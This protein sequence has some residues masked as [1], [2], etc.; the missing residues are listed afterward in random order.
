MSTDRASYGI[1]GDDILRAAKDAATGRI[2]RSGKEKKAFIAVGAARRTILTAYR[3]LTEGQAEQG[4]SYPEAIAENH[5]TVNKAQESLAHIAR[6][7]RRERF[8]F[9]SK[10]HGRGKIRALVLCEELLRITDHKLDYAVFKSFMDAYQET[11]P[12]DEGEIL[13]IPLFIRMLCVIKAAEVYSQARDML[14]SMQKA[15]RLYEKLTMTQSDTAKEKILQ[16]AIGHLSESG[17]ATLYSLFADNDDF[18]C[19]EILSGLLRKQNMSLRTVSINDRQQKLRISEQAVNTAGT[20]RFCEMLSSER[21]L[22]DFSVLEKVLRSDGVYCSLDEP[23]QRAYCSACAKIAQR[24]RISQGYVAQKACDLGDVSYYLMDR[25]GKRE[26]LSALGARVH[27][28]SNGHKLA[29]HISIQIV[30]TAVLVLLCSPAGAVP[31]ALSVF[32]SFVFVNTL[33]MRV[34][35]F[36]SKPVPVPRMHIEG[37]SPEKTVTAVSVLVTDEKALC[38]C[39]ERIETHYLASNLKNTYYAVLGDFPDSRN[40][41]ETDDEKRLARLAA[42]KTRMLN[43]K[44]SDG[45]DIFC[46]LIRHRTHNKHDDIYMGYERKRGAVM[47]FFDLIRNDAGRGNYSVIAGELPHGIKYALLLDSDTCLPKG[48]L[49]S[50]IG[51]AMHP[52]NRAVTEKGRVTKGYGIFIP[53]MERIP[54]SDTGFMHA[55][56]GTGGVSPYSSLVCDYYHDSFGEAVFGGKGLV[57]IDAFLE[58]LHGRIEDNTVLSHDMLES[59]FVKGAYVSDVILYDSEPK[60]LISWWKRAHRWIRGDWQLLP[61]LLAKKDSQ[62]Y[63][64]PL[65]KWKILDNMRRSLTPVFVLQSLLILPYFGM[66]LYVWLSLFCAFEEA[67]IDSLAALRMYMLDGHASVRELGI[68]WERCFIDFMSLPYATARTVDAVWRALHRVLFSHRNML[69]WQTA[70][71]SEKKTREKPLLY[72]AELWACFWTG[73]RL[74]ILPLFGFHGSVILGV[75]FVYA[76]FALRIYDA[77]FRKESITDGTRA[78]YTELA[79]DIWDFFRNEAKAEHGYIPPDNVQIYPERPPVYNASPTNI[80]MG[81]TA[82]VCAHDLGLSDDDELIHRASVCMDYMDK[83]EKWNGHLYNWYDL[84]SA[85]KLT[86]AYVSTVDS[87]NLC[88]CLLCCA[89]ALEETGRDEALICA[90]RMR[91]MA[92]AMDFAALYDNE[93]NLFYIG[94]DV[95]R[96]ELTQSRYDLLASEAR[97]TYLTACAL[98][99]IPQKSWKALGR[100]LTRTQKGRSLAS[101]SGT[102]FEYLMPCLFTGIT[103]DTLMDECIHAAV[104]EFISCADGHPWGISESGYYAFDR[105]MYYQYRAFGAPLLGLAPMYSYE[106]VYAPYASCLA[107]MC[108]PE[109]ACENLKSFSNIGARGRYGFYEAVDFTPGRVQEGHECEIVKSYMAHH[110]GMS[111]CALA[112]I[113]TDNMLSKRFMHIPEMRAVRLYCDEKI[114]DDALTLKCSERL[115]MNEDDA[116]K[117]Y[118]PPVYTSPARYPR[119]TFLTNGHMTA[120]C[121]DSGISYLRTGDTFVTRYRR[122][123]IRGCFGL[124]LYIR[125]GDKVFCI[126][127]SGGDAAYKSF[128]FE[129]YRAAVETDT[130]DIRVRTESIVAQGADALCIKITVAN[131]GTL[132]KTLEIGAFAGI[133]LASLADDTAHPA[134]INLTTDAERMKD[135]VMFIRRGTDRR[136]AMYAYAAFSESEKLYVSADGLSAIGRH[137]SYEDAM[138]MRMY[139]D[140]R[141]KS[142]TEPVLCMKSEIRADGGESREYTFVFAA[143]EDRE[144]TEAAVS[145]QMSAD[146]AQSRSLC[147]AMEMS[148]LKFMGISEGKAHILSQVAVRIASGA[149]NVKHTERLSRARMDALYKYSISGELPIVAV[150]IG[151]PTQ[152][153]MLK[154]LLALLRFCAYKGEY[155]DLVIIGRYDM[156]YRCDVKSYITDAAATFMMSEQYG[157]NKHLHIADGY[158]MTDDEITLIRTVAVLWIDASRSLD[159]QFAD[160]PC[161]MS[162][163]PRICSCDSV[164]NDVSGEFLPSGAYTFELGA[165]DDTPLPWS[166]IICSPKNEQFGTLV[167][168]SGGGYTWSGNCHDNRLTP[169][170]CDI[171]HDTQGE[172]LLISDKENNVRTVTHSRMQG[173]GNVRITHGFGYTVFDNPDCICHA[174]MTVF[175]DTCCSQKISLLELEN[176][177]GR[178]IKLTLRYMADR[179]G[180]AYTDFS[181]GIACM[182]DPHMPGVTYM[183]M[184]NADSVRF[185]GDREGELLFYSKTEQ[186]N[187]DA[188]MCLHGDVRLRPNEKRT[189]ILILGTAKDEKSAAANVSGVTVQSAREKLAAVPDG[190]ERKLSA[191]RV[192]TPDKEFDTMVNGRL[193]YQV[194]ASRLFSRTGFYQSGGAFGF[195]DQLQDVLALLYTD[196]DRAKGQILLCASMQFEAGDCLHWWHAPSRGVRTHITD[197]RLFLP[198]VTAE[199]VKVTGDRGILSLR[200]PYLEDV[201][202]A[203]DVHD[204]Y[205]NAG[206][207]KHDGTLYEHC[208]ASFRASD[209]TGAHGLPLMGGGDWNDGMDC[210]GKDGGESVFNAFLIIVTAEAFLPVAI[211]ERDSTGA[212]YLRDKIQQLRAAADE[213]A[214]DGDWFRRAYFGDGAILG[215]RE[216]SECMIDLLTQAWGIFAMRKHSPEKC[217]RAM[218]S[219]RELLRD[220]ANSTIKLLMPPFSDDGRHRTGYIES[221]AE[222]VRENGAQYTHAAVWY[223]IA[224]CMTQSDDEVMRI[225]HMLSP[226]GKDIKAY[227]AEPYAVAADVYSCDGY[228]GRGGWTWYTGSASWLYTASVRYIA[229][230]VK[231]GD[232]LRIEPH[233]TWDEYDISYRYGRTLYRIHVKRTEGGGTG[234]I[235]LCDDGGVHDVTVLTGRS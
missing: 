235:K 82:A 195:R 11:A 148:A 180:G 88:A 104:D 15:R 203:D 210:V 23:S 70:A 69:E 64:S 124:K 182:T 155:F 90:V 144:R 136:P 125:D 3:Q 107:A 159:R 202:L 156:S 191:L 176:T 132:A 181:G 39:M 198:Y 170:Y 10:T 61:Y 21:L 135:G 165:N 2:I 97:L 94:Y 185:S 98:D 37:E 166:N 226:A 188:F 74:L 45:E 123:H 38:E 205:I 80:G 200:I 68:A 101:W 25:D 171:L 109:K 120:L 36:L 95:T 126:N 81:L 140:K 96:C 22:R 33:F 208:M 100:V 67:V 115:I 91:N 114:P 56:N 175:A 103:P 119:G 193:L 29:L 177:E 162:E 9:I 4:V 75:F 152:F 1:S 113:L 232:I 173:S 178:E 19:T 42:E 48:A 197:D 129:P 196:P 230:L 72:Y 168:E 192:D 47:Q 50:L 85:Q 43:E 76:P 44:Y 41:G 220:D 63:T 157:E 222:G 194:Y 13:L 187:S 54:A 153:R 142:P 84:K 18:V 8:T 206:H 14:L 209:K 207:S 217:R 62:K 106:A 163:M 46:F 221:Y 211:A 26:L 190:W 7:M 58:C 6:Q 128:R 147:F 216:N 130:G 116:K 137:R 99:K 112:N 16:G 189:I 59:S 78:Y 31:T 149:G 212:A 146:F 184:Q 66:G 35:S 229:G 160:E 53:R 201:P 73:G 118:S 204:I 223:L 5:Y 49:A 150:E 131:P 110:Q 228:A 93:K 138:R 55:H 87:G 89:A 30:F 51:A 83:L 60:T 122:D 169:W 92:K 151:S 34:V 17:Y 214:W 215:S 28:F 121:T 154:T 158:S 233:N 133:S 174:T 86:P 183:H 57:D 32:S 52:Q 225:W 172:L 234:V 65:T 145:S 102:C 161:R 186:K 164:P 77:P 40:E 127:S 134:F 218:E 227:M 213:Y 108:Y 71:Q 27:T 199:Y 224:A 167:T 231:N 219:V 143:G 24:L 179:G 79:A 111:I 141:I 139:S 105:S 20:L 12:L 117:K